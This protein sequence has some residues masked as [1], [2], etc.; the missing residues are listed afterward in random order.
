[1]EAPMSQH[2]LGGGWIDDS[3]GWSRELSNRNG[4]LSTN[5]AMTL[6]WVQ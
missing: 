5:E 3:G 6:F 1:M 2:D 4:A